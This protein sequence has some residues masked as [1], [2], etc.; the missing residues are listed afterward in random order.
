MRLYT[1]HEVM[2]R[3]Y[4]KASIPVWSDVD[5]VMQEVSL[6]AWRKFSQLNKHSEF[7][8]WACMIARYEILMFRRK[9][10]RDRLLLSEDVLQLLAEEGASEIEECQLQLK[11]LEG[12]VEKL[13]EQR[14]H[15]VRSAYSPDHSI[16]SLAKLF[17]KTEGAFY[18]LLARIRK[19]LLDCM[20]SGL[21]GSGAGHEA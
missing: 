12:C 6:A 7:G 1:Q 11:V 10:A 18:Q 4:V 14:K 3:A 15:I 17:G 5:E 21:A 16:K 20:T 19:E 13:T 2:L 8:R 9:H